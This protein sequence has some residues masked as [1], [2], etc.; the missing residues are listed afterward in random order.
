MIGRLIVL[1]TGAFAFGY[2]QHSF[3]AG[4]WMF[5]VLDYLADLDCE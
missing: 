5:I 4:V 1:L 3:L 2:W